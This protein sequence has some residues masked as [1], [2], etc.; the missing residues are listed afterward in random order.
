MVTTV[1]VVETVAVEVSD[2]ASDEATLGLPVT[3][4]VT[5]RVAVLDTVV[6]VVDVS[7]AVVVE[8]L[9]ESAL[10]PRALVSLVKV[11]GE[12]AMTEVREVVSVITSVVETVMM[13]I[14]VQE[15]AVAEPGEDAAGTTV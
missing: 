1:N 13:E 7:E 4:A 11:T 2:E 5:T 15:A 12:V 14:D 8:N 3:P 9:E 10:E 6:T